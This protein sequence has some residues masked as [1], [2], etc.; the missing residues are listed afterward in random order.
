MRQKLLRA[1]PVLG[2]TSHAFKA[3][4][5]SSSLLQKRG[6]FTFIFDH[7][8]NQTSVLVSDFGEIATD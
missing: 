8:Q 4:M 1:T 3:A 7:R 2:S 6:S 5:G